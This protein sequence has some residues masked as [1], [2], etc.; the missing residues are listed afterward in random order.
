MKICQIAPTGGNPAWQKLGLKEIPETK[1]LI[2]LANK[3]ED[4]KDFLQEAKDLKKEIEE[5]QREFPDHY[6]I[7]ITVLDLT[8]ISDD[9]YQL[10][11]YFKELFSQ[12]ISKGYKICINGSSGLQIWKLALYQMTLLF[13]MDIHSFFLFNKKNQKMEKIWIQKELD[14]NEEAILDI[15]KEKD[16][17]SLGI[18]QTEFSSKMGKG[19][20]SYMVKLIEKLEKNQL[21]ER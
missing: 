19:N 12:I 11:G 1:W 14:K 6:Q 2:I 7:Q 16:K 10:L 15:L 8:T 9:Y 4:N 5:E 17:I 18:L 3:P 20:L 21:I 13:K